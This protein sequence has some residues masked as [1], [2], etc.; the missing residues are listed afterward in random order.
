M[1]NQVYKNQTVKYDL[2]NIG[3]D[4]WSLTANQGYSAGP[5]TIV[6][7]SGTRSSGIALDI[8]YAS[9]VWT[10]LKAGLYNIS[11]SLHWVPDIIGAYRNG[12][13]TLTPSGGTA[14]QIG[15]STL[16]NNTTTATSIVVQGSCMVNAGIGDTVSINSVVDTSGTLVGAVSDP[17]SKVTF[18]R[19][20]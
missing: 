18:A 17:R 3:D 6:G 10:F 19:V 5:N 14:T 7:W 16:I 15:Y 4:E 20:A 11:F 13:I 12:Y 8:Q 2:A 1:S 9:G